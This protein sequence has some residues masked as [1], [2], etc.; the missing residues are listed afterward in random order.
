MHR[1]P[2]AEVELVTVEGDAAEA[3]TAQ[4]QEAGL[5]VV[6]SQ[7]HRGVPGFLLGSTTRALVQSAMCPVVVL[8]AQSERLWPVVG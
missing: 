6:A 8:T 2:R 3:L 7:G 5:L 4:S 1:P